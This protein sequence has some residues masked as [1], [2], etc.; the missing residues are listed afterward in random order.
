MIMMPKTLILY[1]STDGHTIEICRRI[2][3]VMQAHGQQVT[4]R[5]IDGES[6]E[7]LEDFGQIVIG[8]SIRY[9]RHNPQVATF[10]SRH[11]PLLERK[12]NAFFSVN[13]VARKQEKNSPETNPYLQKFLRKISWQPDQLAVFAGKINYP[14]CKPM[15]RFMIRLIMWI[16]KGPT[17]TRGV[18][19]FTDWDAVDAFGSALCD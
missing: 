1:S 14:F 15:D 3:Q 10:I 19:E 2:Q 11:Q 17:D 16:T 7:D 6:G 12:R 8:A 4:V 18:F 5:A 13:A 9:G